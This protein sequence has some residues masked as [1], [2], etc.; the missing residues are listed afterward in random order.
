MGMIEIAYQIKDYADFFVASQ[1]IAWA[2]LGPEG[3]YIQ[4]ISGIQPNTA[5]RDMAEM[6]VNSYAESIP[7][8]QHPFTIS[9]ID[10]AN[11]EMLAQ[12]TSQLALA[13]SESL[14]NPQQAAILL[15]V[16]NK[17]QKIDYDADL[18]IEPE[19]DGFIDLYDFALKVVDQYSNPE[20][21][22][23]AQNLIALLDTT[24]IAAEHFTDSPWLFP[25]R[26]W[27]LDNSH[28][29]SI[30][31]PLGEDLEYPILVTETISISP[32]VVTTR[33]LRLRDMY[34]GTQL[35]YVSDTSWN[36]L[37][38]T[39]YEIVSVSP[40]LVDHET[41]DLQPVDY[42]APQST[43]TV[44]GVT[45]V[46]ETILLEWSTSDTQSGIKNITIWH[47]PLYYPWDKLGTYPNPS[48]TY[49]FLL[50]QYCQNSFAVL[51]K[52]KAGNQELILPY[53][54]TSTIEVLPC[55]ELLLPT[56][57]R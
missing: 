39:Y 42:T 11:M 47:R 23:A 21:D 32:S 48:G 31:L 56:I 50:T 37:I 57:F 46:G 10:M 36:T 27:N 55:D 44:T 51:A 7:P 28:G 6:L 45:E 22:L 8:E 24:I 49:P 13:L 41:V 14:T 40:G 5:P 2:P 25:D 3:R 4:T 30:F 52:D 17:T 53:V 33:N 19:T 1:N 12:A 9:A 34:T 26:V 38:S 16:Y 18:Y 29:L 15:D 43:I 54:N 35:Q 20:I